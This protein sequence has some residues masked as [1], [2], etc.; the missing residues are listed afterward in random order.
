MWSETAL[1][2][3]SRIAACPEKERIVLEQRLVGRKVDLIP[4]D[5]VDVVT[6]H[7]EAAIEDSSAPDLLGINSQRCV[8]LDV[9]YGTRKLGRCNS[10]LRNLK[11]NH[12]LTDM[13][14]H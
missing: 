8:D 12:S 1:A 7:V 3:R 2:C 9:N 4:L 14:R 10:S 6:V 13:C 11:P 5:T